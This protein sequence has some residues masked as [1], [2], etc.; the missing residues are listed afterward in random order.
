MHK[1]AEEELQFRNVLLRTQQEVS[2]DGILVVG[3]NGAILSSNQ[4]FAEMWGLPST[5]AEKQ[6]DAPLL[7]VVMSKTKNPKV[8]F[9]RVQ[10]LYAH[11]DETGRDE[12]ELSDGRTFD[13]YS[14]PMLGADGKYYGRVWYFRDITERRQAEEALREAMVA[15]EAAAKAKAM[16]LANMSHEIRTPMN[17]IIG[18]NGLLLDTGLTAEQRQYAETVSSSAQALLSVVNDILDFSKIEAGKLTSRH[19]I[20]I[21]GPRSMT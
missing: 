18:M 4:R 10:Y 21:C 3:E 2:I 19:L 7:Q 16:F 13:R 5:I 14:A 6:D 15:A 8:F 11:R 12:I 1:R 17:G 20:S 9:D